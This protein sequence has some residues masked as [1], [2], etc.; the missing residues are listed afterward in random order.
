M[1]D[2]KI[3]NFAQAGRIITRLA[4]RSQKHVVGVFSPAIINLEKEEVGEDGLAGS[5]L[6]P[7]DGTITR[8]AIRVPNVTVKEPADISLELV[9]D[10]VKTILSLRLKKEQ[11]STE[12]SL[13]VSAGSV[14]TLRAPAKSSI[15]ASM[16]F[17]PQVGN[18]KME[19]YLLDNI[20]GAT[21]EG[22]RDAIDES[23][24]NGPA[25]G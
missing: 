12:Y 23:A 6:F 21:D 9:V 20:E 24:T 4:R 16:L 8:V 3:E 18:Y 25:K 17:V 2:I 13:S 5:L 19:Q 11:S 14:L 15:L 10:N 22:I 1:K 7:C